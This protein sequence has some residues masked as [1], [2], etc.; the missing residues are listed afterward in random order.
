MSL[1]RLLY[2]GVQTLAPWNKLFRMRRTSSK[3][4]LALERLVS[5]GTFFHVTRPFRTT[6]LRGGSESSNLTA[7]RNCAFLTRRKC[8]SISL[9][10]ASQSAWTDL[11]P[12]LAY[13]G[14]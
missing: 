11:S 3:T 10:K 7:A 5:A 8:Q 6:C 13:P 4:C 9:A 12:P 1:A 2:S 14:L